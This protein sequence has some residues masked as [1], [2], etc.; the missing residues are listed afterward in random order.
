LLGKLIE[1]Q[2]ALGLSD[3]DFARLVELPRSSWQAT[4][5]G[6]LPLAPR[7][8]RAALRVWPDLA[9]AALDWLRGEREEGVS[10]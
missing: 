8:V 10:A 7:V 1:K 4:R 5:V 6:E 9:G 2:R 3:A